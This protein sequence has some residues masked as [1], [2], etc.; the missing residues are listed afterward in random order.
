MVAFT[1]V[2]N[3][4]RLQASMINRLWGADLRRRNCVVWTDRGSEVV[5]YPSTLQ[6]RLAD[7]WLVSTVDLES[8]QTGRETLELV[9]FLGREDRG[10]GPK[11]TS[12]LEGRDSSGLRTRWIAAV[13]AALWDGVL[14][15]IE[16]TLD[17]SRKQ[18]VGRAVSIVGFSGWPDGLAL[19]MREDMP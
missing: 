3:L 15:Q 12:T 1:Q 18:R 5:V 8:E 17:M 11:A 19:H 4:Q 16:Q 14:D 10:S 2:V 7:G 9:F 13:Q 6:V